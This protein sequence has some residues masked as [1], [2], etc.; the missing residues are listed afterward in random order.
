M[1]VR[2]RIV[3]LETG[4]EPRA[5]RPLVEEDPEPPP[6]RDPE[7]PAPTRRVPKPPDPPAPPA[8]PSARLQH[9]PPEPAPDDGALGSGE[10]LSLEEPPPDASD[11]EP[12][13]RG[14]RG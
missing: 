8:P 12:W 4:Y 14:L 10:V 7:P 11:A 3:D 1:E 5:M 13:K 2:A 9:R 6:P